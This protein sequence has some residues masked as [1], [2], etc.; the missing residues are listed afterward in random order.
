[1]VRTKPLISLCYTSCRPSY[2]KLVSEMWINK[3]TRGDIEVVIAVDAGNDKALAAAKK[4]PNAKVF[5]QESEPFNCV[6]GWN[7]AAE[8][9]EGELIIC[10]ADDFVPPQGWDQEILNVRTDPEDL[11]EAR[12]AAGMNYPSWIEDSKCVWVNDGFNTTIATLSILTRKR[13][14]QFGYVFYPGYESM[15]CDTEYTEKAKLDGAMIDARHL[16][17]EHVHPAAGKRAQ[18]AADNVHASKERWQRGETL[19]NMRKDAGFPNDLGPTVGEAVEQVETPGRKYAAYIQAIKDDFCLWEVCY[20]LYE[21]GVRS[22]FFCIPD[23]YWSGEPVPVEE[24]DQ[25]RGV[26]ERVAKELEDV[27]VSVQTFRVDQYRQEGRPRIQVETHLRNDSL[28][29]IRSCG[30]QHI[31][32]VDGDELW[33]K[34]LL[35]LVDATITQTGADAVA[36]H[37]IPTVGLP[38][39][40]V[41]NAQDKVTVYIGNGQSF[42]DC[43]SPNGKIATMGFYGVY[44]FT[45][46]RKTMQEIIDKHRNS[47]HYDD[48]NYDFEGWIANTLPHAR[49]GLKNA[50]MYIPYQIWPELRAWSRKELSDIPESLHEYLG[51]EGVVEHVEERVIPQARVDS[52]PSQSGATT[53]HGAPKVTPMSFGRLKRPNLYG[54]AT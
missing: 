1:M 37:M 35:K 41:D 54:R 20:R 51:M 23:Q 12:R 29:W 6:K 33:K 34:G 27:E 49:P 25:V 22:F 24:S 14:N 28:N 39:Y 38:G 7:L 30:Y 44:H 48:A 19:F 47:G 3:A 53:A 11:A 45:A 50:H 36:C 17:I 2:I 10:I 52:Q 16:V 26:A 9:S 46:T 42:R 43:R 21:D 32:I 13:Y 4:V 8:K 5:I 40:P 18:D 31:L 15:F